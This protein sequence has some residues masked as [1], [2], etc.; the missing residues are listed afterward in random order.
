MDANRLRIAQEQAE[1]E[2]EHSQ[3]MAQKLTLQM[4]STQMGLA[5]YTAKKELADEFAAKMWDEAGSVAERARALSEK[6]EGAAKEYGVA[7]SASLSEKA[8]RLGCASKLAMAEV[9]QQ[10]A[11]MELKDIEQKLNEAMVIIERA[12]RVGENGAKALWEKRQSQQTADSLSEH[13]SMAQI[14]VERCIEAVSEAQK[15]LKAAAEAEVPIN[16]LAAE[17]DAARI[18]AQGLAQQAELASAGAE[19]AARKAEQ[20]A[21]VAR[22]AHQGAETKLGRELPAKEAADEAAEKAIEVLDQARA[23]SVAA[24]Q[25]EIDCEATASAAKMACERKQTEWQAL[26]ADAKAKNAIASGLEAKEVTAKE[27][28]AL[29]AK[30]EADAV[31]AEARQ[32]DLREI[33]TETTSVAKSSEA[34]G[35][36]LHMTRAGQRTTFQIEAR[37]VYGD[38]VPNGGDLFF[39]SIRYCGQGTRLRAKVLDNKD[40]T[41][42]VTYKP[43]STGRITISVSLAGKPLEGSPFTCNVR[44]PPQPCASTCLVSGDALTRA[45]AGNKEVFTISF[46]DE[47]GQLT[48]ATELDVCVFPALFPAREDAV[49]VG[50]ME[51][52]PPAD[53]TMGSPR[54]PMSPSSPVQSS[55]STE[56]SRYWEGGG[57]AGEKMVVATTTLDLTLTVDE[58]STW[59]GKTAP[60]LGSP[61]LLTVKPGPAHPLLTQVQQPLVGHSTGLPPEHAEQ[62]R[63][64][65]SQAAGRAKQ[66]HED[67]KERERLAALAKQP[68]RPYVA[69]ETNEMH[70][71][72]SEAAAA[73]AAAAREAEARAAEEA[74]VRKSKAEKAAALAE[75]AAADL[76]RAQWFSC[77]S[78][79]IV[80]DRMG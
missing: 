14:R 8:Q 9:Q 49:A 80:R 69:A 48:F 50:G 22:A 70:E 27:A 1:A 26:L 67:E 75:K 72:T 77:T 15:S 24:R 33:L 2:L 58:D 73:A 28:E 5:D 52:S 10:E 16:V 32:Y 78:E 55:G 64:A 30:L 60:V 35:E 39:V 31:A 76:A 46:R 45:V 38:R 4:A 12:P 20:A 71:N 11:E 51:A 62:L 74:L 41:Y 40:G 68:R 36:G 18:E 56:A 57:E 6:A 21:R 66:R 54:S 59:L 43:G 61:F 47:L 17:L 23:R 25:R 63:T 3:A 53:R 65:A 34:K 29:A 42:T 44:A 13:L 79:L 37:D 7:H 19:A